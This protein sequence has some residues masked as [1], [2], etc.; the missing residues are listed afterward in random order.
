M[1][2]ARFPLGLSAATAT[3]VDVVP[4]TPEEARR[5]LVTLG[6]PPRLQRHA[7]LVGEALELLLLGYRSIGIAVDET[8]V[9][10]GATLHDIGK[11]LCGDELQGPGARHEAA[12]ERLLLEHGASPEVARVCRSHAQWRDPS[13]SIAELVVSLADKLWKGARVTELEEMFVDRVA[14]AFGCDRWALST[15][16]DSLFAEVA[17]GADARLLRS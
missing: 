10:V 9:R 8:F 15:Q 16:C 6:A 14:E 12:G 2:F 7:V 3:N 13:N 4:A 1:D 11:I 17:A 5:L